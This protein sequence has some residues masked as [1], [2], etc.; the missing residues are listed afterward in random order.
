MA[1]LT[2][3]ALLNEI[4]ENRISITTGG[5]NN[6]NKTNNT[7]YDKVYLCVEN[8]NLNYVT[9]N[10]NCYSFE[11]Y[12]K[13]D[14]YY[15]KNIRY[16]CQTKN[17]KHTMVPMCKWIPNRFHSYFLNKNLKNMYWSDNIKIIDLF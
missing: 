12:E 17:I 5:N 4:L 1:S 16:I 11:T 2:E 13:A 8:S 14:E 10:F 15:K 3:S 6:N 7:W 9:G